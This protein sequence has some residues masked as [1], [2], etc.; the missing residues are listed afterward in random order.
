MWS[1]AR[2]RPSRWDS[3]GHCSARHS[4]STG[5]TLFNTLDFSKPLHFIVRGDGY[6]T[7]GSS[8]AALTI[9]LANFGE[10]AR[11]PAYTWLIGLA[12]CAEKDIDTL[13]E[14]WKANIKVLSPPF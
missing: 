2:V 5:P 13:G 6:P 11:S 12:V 7:A 1:T 14:L 8:W 9:T 3:T 10:D 4:T